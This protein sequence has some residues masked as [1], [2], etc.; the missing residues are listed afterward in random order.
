MASTETTTHDDKKSRLKE[1]ER[2]TQKETQSLSLTNY[3]YSYRETTTTTTSDDNNNA[4]S[5][6]SCFSKVPKMRGRRLVVSID[7]T[8]ALREEEEVSLRRSAFR[9]SS[10]FFVFNRFSDDQ[11]VLQKIC[12]QIHYS[13]LLKLNL[14][15]RMLP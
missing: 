2:E 12:L 13:Q 5:P 6:R 11:N 4:S 8:K 15:M 7:N 10:I 9:G 14:L 1:R 3:A